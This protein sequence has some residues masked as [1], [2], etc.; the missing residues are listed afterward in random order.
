MSFG[1][2]VCDRDGSSCDLAPGHS[3]VCAGTL[4]LCPTSLALLVQTAS[5]SRVVYPYNDSIVAMGFWTNGG[6]AMGW[7]DT[8][9]GRALHGSADFGAIFRDINLRLYLAGNHAI[10]SAPRCPAIAPN[11]RAANRY[12]SPNLSI[13]V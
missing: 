12:G 9:P 5:V 10:F 4:R 8:P 1:D 11:A 13:P 7:I 6:V 2:D 3:W